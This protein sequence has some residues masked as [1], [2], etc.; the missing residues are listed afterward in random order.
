[1]ISRGLF[2]SEEEARDAVIAWRATHRPIANPERDAQYLLVV[3]SP[4]EERRA[5]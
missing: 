5:A 3:A 2:D 1:M 4:V